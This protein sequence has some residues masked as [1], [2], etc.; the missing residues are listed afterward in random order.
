MD[1]ELL[2]QLEGPHLDRAQAERTP[3]LLNV[4]ACHLRQQDWHAAIADCQEVRPVAV[5]VAV[6]GVHGYPC[7]RLLCFHIGPAAQLSLA[8]CMRAK[9]LL[10]R[11]AH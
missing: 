10:V 8:P 7:F 4:A 5:A 6:A 3:L 2:I 9:S 1:E 11:R